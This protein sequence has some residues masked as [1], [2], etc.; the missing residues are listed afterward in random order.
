MGVLNTNPITWVGGLVTSAM[1]NAQVRDPLTALQAAWTAYTP[2][3]TAVTTNPSLGNGTLTGSYHRIGKTI[4]FTISL[5]IGSTTTLGSGGWIFSL[6]VNAGGSASATPFNSQCRI[7]GNLIRHAL[8]NSNSTVS[9]YHVDGTIM[10]GTT[11][12]WASGNIMSVS[13]IYEAA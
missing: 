6:P 10:T 12:A 7:P 8:L 1:M 13:G 9:L 5:T 11:I 4:F 2:T 3:W